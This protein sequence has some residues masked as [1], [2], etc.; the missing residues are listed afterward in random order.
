M[1]GFLHS[2]SKVMSER[3]DIVLLVSM[4]LVTAAFNFVY[5]HLC[6]GG[7]FA[8][9]RWGIIKWGAIFLVFLA[10]VFCCL[11]VSI[12]DSIY[13][14]YPF[15]L[16]PLVLITTA[17]HLIVCRLCRGIRTTWAIIVPIACTLF[18]FGVNLLNGFIGPP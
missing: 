5:C 12:L 2:L 10:V 13:F 11:F 3:P 7:R 6:E 9:I 16:L 15:S 18:Y 1:V 17:F 4:I 14:L 8:R